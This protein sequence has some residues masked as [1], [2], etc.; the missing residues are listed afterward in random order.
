MNLEAES[1]FPKRWTIANTLALLVGYILYTPIAHGLSGGHP[2]GLS[3]RDRP[4]LAS[5]SPAAQRVLDRR[6][7]LDGR[8]WR[9]DQRSGPPHHVASEEATFG[10]D[11]PPA[12][13][14]Q[15]M[16]V[17]TKSSFRRHEHEED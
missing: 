5:E 13:C 14:G 8:D 10:A 17:T 3:A 16:R 12:C 15:P 9:L 4:G 11:R 6:R 2:Q 1:S 7:P